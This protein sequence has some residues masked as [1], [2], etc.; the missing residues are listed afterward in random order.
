LAT[1][2]DHALISPESLQHFDTIIILGANGTLI[3][4]AGAIFTPERRAEAA[5]PATQAD[6]AESTPRMT[7]WLTSSRRMLED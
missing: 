1:H 2:A 4:T 6:E 5:E 7:L 3:I